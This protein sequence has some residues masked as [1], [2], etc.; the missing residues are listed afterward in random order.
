MAFL[1]SDSHHAEVLSRERGSG[2]SPWVL[3]WGK[4][5]RAI[6]TERSGQVVWSLSAQGLGCLTAKLNGFVINSLHWSLFK[7][8]FMTKFFHFWN[9]NQPGLI[10]EWPWTDHG[11]IINWSRADCRLII[12]WLWSNHW[13]CVFL[14]YRCWHDQVGFLVIPVCLKYLPWLLCKLLLFN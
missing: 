2:E 13:Y 11:L 7:N 8:S 5:W 10:M 9:W 3:H 1:L 6:C 4:G 12:T 14:H